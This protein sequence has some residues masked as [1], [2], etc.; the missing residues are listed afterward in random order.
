MAATATR[1][2]AL[3]CGGDLTDWA[4]FDPF[5]ARAGTKVYNPYFIYV[6]EHP[7]AR[8]VFDTGAHPDL[9]TDP[10]GRLGAAADGFEVELAPGD[11]LDAALAR[12]DLA[13]SDIDLVVQSHLHFDHAGGL[14]RLPGVPVM[15]QAQ[16]LE[17]AR[18]PPVYQAEIYVQDDFAGVQE[19]REIEGDHDVF[20]DGSVMAIAT[21]GHT[22]GHQ[23]LLVR[24]AGQIV[25]LLA[26][27]GY[28]LE[29]MRARA[30]PAV[31]WSP[32]AMIATWD[33][34]EEIERDTG[35]LLLTTH[36]L[37]YETTVRLAPGASYA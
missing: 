16:E 12:I 3:H 28:L 15:V 9:A 19:W 36:E 34:V 1:I 2:H 26:D 20:G 29:K 25:F 22:K 10:A 11:A 7:D 30:L 37:T 27:A 17:F 33:R 4:I 21:P 31:C 24:L 5:D 13:P 18:H 32:D 6:I 35:A 23:S 8:I 14:D